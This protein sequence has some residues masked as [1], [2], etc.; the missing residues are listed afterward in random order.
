M[1]VTQKPCRV[2]EDEETVCI[3]L[4]AHLKRHR[5]D[6]TRPLGAQVELLK[7][8]NAV[9]R[10]I[11]KS[12]NVRSDYACQL[13]LS[14]VLDNLVRL[15]EQLYDQQLTLKAVSLDDVSQFLHDEPDMGMESSM[16]NG[17]SIQQQPLTAPDREALPILAKDVLSLNSTVSNMLKKRPLDGFQM[18]GRHETFHIAMEQRLMRVI[19][20]L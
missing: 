11:L 13:L 14:N 18:L 19:A 2:P 10:R 1:P 16:L 5:R 15:C 9:V 6:E 8:S 17:G 7:K 4:L 3:K 20:V 12:K